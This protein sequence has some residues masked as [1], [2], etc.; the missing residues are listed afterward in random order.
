MGKRGAAYIPFPQAV[1]LK[2][3][4][5]SEHC[6]FLTKGKCTQKCIKACG[7]GAI[8][9]EQKVKEVELKVGSIIIATGFKLDD[10]AKKPEYGYGVYENVINSLQIERLLNPSGPTGG[11]VKRPSDNAFPKKVAFLQCVCSRDS[12]TNLYCSRFCCM[13]AIKEAILLKE[14]DPDIEVTIF[15]IDIRAFG[16]GYEE[17]YNR[18]QSE[19][20]IK[21][22]KGR[23]AEISE[24]EDKNLITKSE[25]IAAGGIVENEFDLIVL[26]VGVM[27]NPLPVDI[28]INPPVWRDNFLIA[29]NPY[30]DAVTTEV[31]GVFVAGCAESPKDIPDS[32]TQASAAAMQASIVLEGK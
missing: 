17:L 19:F 1:P 23:I 11:E 20:G 15:Y 5:D 30:I 25:D 28:G 24:K 13:Q 16:K 8:D 7:P 3:T 26:S 29:K 21:F 31:P 32:V 6:Q 10:P 9:F 4:I 27:P 14:H 2:A 18:A 22:V 12:N